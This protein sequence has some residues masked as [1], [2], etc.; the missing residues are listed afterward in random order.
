MAVR[1]KKKSSQDGQAS[2]EVVPLLAIFILFAGYGM[3]AFG[4]VHTGILHNIAARTYAFETFRHRANLV[5]FRENRIVPQPEHYQEF[6]M[7]LHAVKHETAQGQYAYATERPIAFGFGNETIGRSAQ[8]HSQT[9]DQ[10]QHGRRAPSNTSVNPAWIKVQ[11]GI[12]INA[13]C[14]NSGT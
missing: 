12:C 3:G 1:K 10:I 7:R 2:L 13:E 11:Y 5:Y 9:V 4:I 6:G 8:T 14:G